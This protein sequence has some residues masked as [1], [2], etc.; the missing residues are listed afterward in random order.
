MDI[1]TTVKKILGE[2]F[3]DRNAVK[4]RLNWLRN[5]FRQELLS[6]ALDVALPGGAFP[7]K[8]TGND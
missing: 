7:I 3:S 1:Y 4:R 5:Y 2:S 8:L 6:R